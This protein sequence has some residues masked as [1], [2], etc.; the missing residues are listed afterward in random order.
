MRHYIFSTCLTLDRKDTR[1]PDL[2]GTPSEY[3]ICGRHRV[4]YFFHSTEPQGKGHYSVS[5]SPMLKSQEVAA[6]AGRN[7]SSPLSK[8]RHKDQTKALP[9]SLPIQIG[10]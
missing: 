7:E 2:K 9:S 5:P 3:A 1:V 10:L 8:G 4:K 6:L